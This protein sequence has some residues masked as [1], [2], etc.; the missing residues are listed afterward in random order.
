M[1]KLWLLGLFICSHWIIAQDNLI[2][3]NEYYHSILSSEEI[4]NGC[5]WKHH[6]SIRPMYQD[7]L[8]KDILNDSTN[9]SSLGSNQT[10]IKYLIK[11]NAN[12]FV[13]HRDSNHNNIYYSNKRTSLLKYIYPLPAYFIAYHG[14]S[15]YF[16]INPLLDLKWGFEKDRADP[17]LMNRRGIRI[18]GGIDNKVFFTTELIESQSAFLSYVND[19]VEE[20]R[21]LPGVGFLKPYKSKLFGIQHGYDYLIAEA[22]IHFKASKHI[23]ISFGHGRQFIGSGERSLF[24]SD[25]S[26]PHFYLKLLTTIGRVNYLNCF[27]ELTSESKYFDDADR[28]LSK[29]YLAA[30]YLSYNVTKKWNVGLFESIVFSRKKNFEFQYLNPIILYRSVEQAVGS[31]DNVMIGLHSNLDLFKSIRLYGQIILDEFVLKQVIIDNQGW[32]ANKY[33]IQLGFKYVN[34]ASIKNLNLLTELNLVRPY[35]YSFRDSTANYAHNHQALAHP[36]GSNFKEW[37][38]KLDYRL[39]KKWYLQS[40]NFISTK[41][42]DTLGNN[43][44]GNILKPNISHNTDFNNVI[45]QGEMRFLTHL[46]LNISYA[47]WHNIWLDIDGGIRNTKLNKEPSL[48]YWFQGGVRMNLDRK[49]MDF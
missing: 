18:Q 20:Q 34:V 10:G 29:K 48:T 40:R 37:V 2:H 35:T 3:L 45:G 47:L 23:D 30:H 12:Y 49:R 28:L 36:L 4:S 24:L 14:K 38:I 44:G 42:L 16:N 26:A 32:W 25:F 31:P 6:T 39:G 46:E 11:E 15:G 33:G 7:V 22:D 9:R 27:S 8:L 43:F 41:G 21:T 1:K 13:Y 17:L 5:L 19:Y